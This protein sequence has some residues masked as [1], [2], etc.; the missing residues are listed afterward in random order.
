MSFWPVFDLTLFSVILENW[1]RNKVGK[2]YKKYGETAEFIASVSD[3]TVR[4]QL[5][6]E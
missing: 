6:T 1:C 2:Q 4:L 3:Y 5:T